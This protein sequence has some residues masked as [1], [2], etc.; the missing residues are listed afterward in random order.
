MLFMS[1][2]WD[3]VGELWL[4]LGLLFISH[5]I[6]E[7]GEPKWNDMDRENLKNSERNLSQCRFVH[8]KSHMGRPEHLQWETSD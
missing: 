7:S 2:E 1:M 5:M 6:Q 8:Q 4:P 3:Y